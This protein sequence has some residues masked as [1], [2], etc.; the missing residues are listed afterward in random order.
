MEPW[1]Q[2]LHSMGRKMKL[3]PEKGARGVVVWHR[4]V[5]SMFLS[6]VLLLFLFMP[7][8]VPLYGRDYEALVDE[9]VDL[10]EQEKL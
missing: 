8:G 4:R 1:R 6:G 5:S 9:V 10:I 3:P 2:Q 7:Y